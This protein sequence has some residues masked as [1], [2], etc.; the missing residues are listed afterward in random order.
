MRRTKEEAAVTRARLLEAA[1]AIFHA[2]GYAA[3]TL[4]DIARQA[5]ITRGAI[6]GI[7]GVK[8]NCIIPWF[9]SPTK[10]LG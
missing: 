8:R 2:K 5:G 4:D 9:A 7:S 10:K 3:T 6:H 1:L